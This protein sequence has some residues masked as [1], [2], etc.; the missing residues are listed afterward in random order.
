MSSSIVFDELASRMSW[1]D[2]KLLT[3][4]ARLREGGIPVFAE[5]G[6]RV[7]RGFADLGFEEFLISTGGKLISL[8]TG[9]VSKPEQL[10]NFFAVLEEPDLIE[11]IVRK[12]WDPKRLE[13]RELRTWE[14]TLENS[15]TG[16]TLTFEGDSITSA[17]AEGLLGI[18]NG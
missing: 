5:E 17:L 2:P 8:F 1:T 4:F 6:K 10:E 12:G 13:Y 11:A 16:A 9:E 7:A 3:K 14:L 15:E 18:Q